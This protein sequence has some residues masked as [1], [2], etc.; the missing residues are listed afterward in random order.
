MNY[1]DKSEMMLMNTKNITTVNHDKGANTPTYKT[2]RAT[3]ALNKK[4]QTTNL[5][6]DALINMFEVVINNHDEN[7]S[8]KCSS[9]F[10]L[11][12][13]NPGFLELSQQASDPKKPLVIDG[14]VLNCSNERASL[15]N[16]DLQFNTVYFFSLS[17]SNNLSVVLGTVTIH[18]HKTSKLVQL[19]GSKLIKGTKA[20][21]WFYNNVLK[22]TLERESV[23]RKCQIDITNTRILNMSSSTPGSTCISCNRNIIGSDKAYTCTKCLNILHKKCTSD[24]GNRSRQ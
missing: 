8:V 18:C 4:K 7:V 16:S 20:P 13:I 17:D 11:E 10:F 24:R 23:K 21:V 2:R 1:T 22:D 19:Q 5:K 14:I 15:D 9:G 6:K 12:V 3:F